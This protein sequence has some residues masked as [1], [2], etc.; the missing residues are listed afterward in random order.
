[1][2]AI[3][4]VRITQHT[5]VIHKSRFKN[6]KLHFTLTDLKTSGNLQGKS[7]RQCLVLKAF[8]SFGS[9]KPLLFF[10]HSHRALTVQFETGHSI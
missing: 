10:N 8:S 6:Q 7:F 5:M 2:S 3:T 1:M 9:V 4:E